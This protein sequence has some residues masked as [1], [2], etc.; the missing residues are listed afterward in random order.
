[1]SLLDMLLGRVKG[2]ERRRRRSSF[3]TGLDLPENLH[4]EDG[5]VVVPWD[6]PEELRWLAFKMAKA[7]QRAEGYDFPSFPRPGIWLTKEEHDWMRDH[8]LRVYLV[9]KDGRAVAYSLV[10]DTDHWHQWRVLDEEGESVEEVGQFT[11]GPRPLVGPLFVVEN[12]RGQGIGRSLLDR[13]AADAGVSPSDIV[14]EVP[15]TRA[16]RLLAMRLR[17]DGTFLSS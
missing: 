13:V 15:L 2:A 11:G 14:G 7:V 8:R 16:G 6:A 5:I 3:K 12:L 9:I 4:L 10:V 17:D 1:M